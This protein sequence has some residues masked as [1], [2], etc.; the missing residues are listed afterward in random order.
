[1]TEEDGNGMADDDDEAEEDETAGTRVGTIG[2]I[3]FGSTNTGGDRAAAAVA[4]D[5]LDDDA[6]VDDE[7]A[8]GDRNSGVSASLIESL[9]MA[10]AP[11]LTWPGSALCDREEAD[12]RVGDGRADADDSEEDEDDEGEESGDGM[13]AVPWS[14]S[15]T[16]SAFLA[17]TEP[18]VSATVSAALAALARAPTNKF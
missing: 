8:A 14:L 1:M 9:P 7:A 5:A 6:D 11:A 12:D 4:A 3:G 18:S 16:N 15:E 10:L 13:A 17:D 2:T